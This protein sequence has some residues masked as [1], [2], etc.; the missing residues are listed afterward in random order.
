MDASGGCCWR[1]AERQP[2][3]TT[4]ARKTIAQID[5]NIP[6]KVGTMEQFHSDAVA[7]PRFRTLLL[8]VFAG[9]AGGLAMVGVYGVMS[10]AAVQR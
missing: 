5:P 2:G 7:L 3:D 8:I 4:A 9:L 6:L 1:Y 10:Y